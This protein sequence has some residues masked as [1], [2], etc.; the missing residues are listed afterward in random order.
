MDY[1]TLT[2]QMFFYPAGRIRFNG[3]LV[4]GD[5]IPGGEGLEPVAVESK[6]EKFAP[7]LALRHIPPEMSRPHLVV[8]GE[9]GRLIK[10][11]F[12]KYFDAINQ[13][14]GWF[15]DTGRRLSSQRR[16]RHLQI[17]IAPRRNQPVGS[18]QREAVS[19]HQP[20]V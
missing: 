6:R 7:Q 4:Q 2:R 8:E 18:I 15:R 5:M 19:F 3:R 16:E 20:L 10:E 17:S 12:G 13:R 1:H 11:I 14:R 9:G